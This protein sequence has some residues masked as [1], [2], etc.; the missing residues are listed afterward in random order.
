[1]HCKS[2]AD[3]FHTSE[4]KI[5]PASFFLKEGTLGVYCPE[6]LIL[7]IGHEAKVMSPACN[8]K[9]AHLEPVRCGLCVTHP[10][11]PKFGSW[12]KK[13]CCYKIAIAFGTFI[14]VQNLA[15]GMSCA[16][17]KHD[18]GSLVDEGEELSRLTVG[19]INK[20][21]W[22]DIIDKSK[23]SALVYVNF[24]V[25]IVSHDTIV[26]QENALV[27]QLLAEGIHCRFCVR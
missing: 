19:T 13:F 9:L 8:Y 1:M 15:A 11:L 22:S 18:M 2:A 20:D 27:L 10:Y 26:G 17:T 12:D 6:R 16:C 3:A 24:S 14:S 23:A 5:A 4:V 21:I 25:V 7:L